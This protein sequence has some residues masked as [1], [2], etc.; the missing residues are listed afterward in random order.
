MDCPCSEH[1]YA[2]S[3]LDEWHGLP[4]EYEAICSDLCRKRPEN[5]VKV[6]IVIVVWKMLISMRIPKTE[7]A[8]CS[9]R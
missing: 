1:P 2:G 4:D 3:H 9:V 7:Q 8:T 6:D 5:E